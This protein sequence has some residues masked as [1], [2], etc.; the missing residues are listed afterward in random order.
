MCT[1]GVTQVFSLI[2]TFHFEIGI[3]CFCG[4]TIEVSRICLSVFPSGAGDQHALLMS[5]SSVGTGGLD[6]GPLYACVGKT[7]I[8]HINRD[9]P[10]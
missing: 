2:S 9:C 8:L 5:C 1:L 4:L 6:S 10:F 3:Q 7:S